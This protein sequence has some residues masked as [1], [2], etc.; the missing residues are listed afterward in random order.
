MVK[1][2]RTIQQH[3]QQEALMKSKFK[4]AAQSRRAA[5]VEDAL[6]AISLFVLLFAA[7]GL[8]GPF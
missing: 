5:L 1:M 2:M 3:T 7:L 8:S 4:I 6:G